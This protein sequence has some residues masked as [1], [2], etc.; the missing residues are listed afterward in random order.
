MKIKY[1]LPK[2]AG[3]GGVGSENMAYST[4]YSIECIY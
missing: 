2:C 3:R 4:M 1:N